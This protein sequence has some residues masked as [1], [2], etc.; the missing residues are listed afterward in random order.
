MI[1]DEVKYKVIADLEHGDSPKDLVTRYELSYPAILKIRRDY[2]EALASNSV[3]TVLAA[4][5]VLIDRIAKEV[6]E[7]G[8]LDPCKVEELTDGI[9]AFS[10]LATDLQETA[11]LLVRNIK[12][13]A[14]LV[15]DLGEVELMVKCISMLQNVFFNKGVTN[16][17]VL[18]Q[19]NNIAN[20]NTVSTFKSLKRA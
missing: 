17:N 14:N 7:E 11:N 6:T 19:Q 9:D 13:Q 15:T 16:L 1:S 12:N 4:D 18:N 20:G 3:D 5:K 10:R 8:I 2:K